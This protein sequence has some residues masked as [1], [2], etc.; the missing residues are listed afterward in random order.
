[1]SRCIAALAVILSAF[2]FTAAQDK[3]EPVPPRFGFGT[4]AQVP[5][6]VIEVDGKDTWKVSGRGAVR[7][8][9][10]IAAYMNATG[11]RV[12]FDADA[13]RQA[14]ATAAYVGA[15]QG[16]TVPHAELGDFV[17]NLLEGVELTLVGHST[18]KAR[19]TSLGD[20]PG[21]ARVV[22]I[23]ELDGLPDSEWVTISR[24]DIGGS[25]IREQL[26]HM[27]TA[28]VIAES[29]DNLFIATGR[30]EQM[31]NVAEILSRIDAAKRGTEGMT[32]RAYDLAAPIKAAD[33]ARVLN[34]L[35]APAESSI[36]SVDGGYQVTSRTTSHVGVS[37][38]PSGN[39][40]IVRA[41][42]ADHVLVKTALDAM[43]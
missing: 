5:F 27:V 9:D 29:Y 39:R 1:M 30:V 6:E 17:S 13:S 8:E 34:D 20:A 7:V 18:D 35:F 28:R 33:A 38:S 10:L 15:D 14:K 26:Q 43:K 2:A 24:A 36:R 37:V 41:T 25:S 23:S 4:K 31:R 32:V 19:V 11:K 3:P 12:T 21:Y 40:V 42:A 16:I 22:E